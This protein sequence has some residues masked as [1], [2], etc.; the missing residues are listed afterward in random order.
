MYNLVQHRKKYY[1]LSAVL[2]S[3]SVLLMVASLVTVGSPF[4][5]S[6][7]FTGGVYWEF[8]L[9]Q[10]VLPGQVRD[11]FVARGLGDTAVTTVGDEN[12]RLQAR[13]KEV[14]P[15]SS[16]HDA[17][18]VGWPASTRNDN[19][20]PQSW[21]TRWIGSPIDANSPVSHSA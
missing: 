13:L 16:T 6:I 14:V 21:A 8:T 7:D 11:V 12:N 10:E 18:F 3:I 19:S 4:R 15:K 9:G 17:M 2:L 1:I 20:A 5:L